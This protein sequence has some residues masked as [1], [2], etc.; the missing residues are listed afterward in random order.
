MPQLS[1]A[2]QGIAAISEPGR[3]R[4]WPRRFNNPRVS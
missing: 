4:V 2:E 3:G 1:A